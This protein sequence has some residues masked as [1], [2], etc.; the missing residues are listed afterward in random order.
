[1]TEICL[2]IAFVFCL[3]I[4][5]C[6]TGFQIQAYSSSK[7]R[8]SH[9]LD[10]ERRNLEPLIQT[11]HLKYQR[12]HND[13]T[14]F[15]PGDNA[16]PFQIKTLDGEFNYP[17]QKKSSV[18]IHAFTNKSAFLECL[19]SSNASL[20]DLVEYL[21]ENTHALFL[22]LDDSA[23]EDALWMREQVYHI[24]SASHR[25]KDVLSRLH[26]SPVPVFALGNWI[27]KVLYSWGCSGH[28]C[29]LAQA[30]FTS[31]A[32]NIPV[33]AK[34]LNARYD[35]LNGHWD[36]KP[37]RLRDGGDGCSPAS[38]VAGA[39]AW[40]TDS[41]CSFFTKVKNMAAS[42]AVGVLVYASTG[43][44]IKDMDCI[45]EECYT[46]LGIPAAMVHLEASV[47]NILRAGKEVNVS[48][49]T[50][51]SPNFFFGIDQQGVLCET[52]WLLYPTF[53]F[54]SWQ[55]QW[56]EYQEGLR[57]H[58]ERPATVVPVFDRVQMQGEHGAQ[59]TVDLPTGGLDYN[60]LEL[61]AS[62][63]CPGRRDETCAHWDHTVQLFVCCD[64][65]SPYCNM[66]LGRWIS[67]FRRGIGRWI[68]DVSPLMP[69]LNNGRCTFTM[70][71]VPWAMPW[72]VTLNLRFSQSNQSAILIKETGNVERLQPFKLTSLFD[73]GTFD[74]GYNKR[75]Q[76]LKFTIPTSTKKVELYAVITGHGSD[77]YGCGEF[78]VTSH[79][80]LV[81][82]IYNNTRI[83]DSA[84]SALGCALRVA[85]G[86]VPNEHGTWLYGRGG[87]CDGL[88]VNPWRV[89][90]TNQL[91]WS[92]ANSIHYFGL[93]EGMDPNPSSNPGYIV[94]CSYLVFYK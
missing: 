69:L 76:P 64:H 91:D 4:N 80:F 17:V 73:G 39:V 88:Q 1:M 47:D 3:F 37:Y 71:T 26:F 25:G 86:A 75:F 85:E 66:E 8:L 58:L 21:P 35:W 5:A 6:L 34:R 94:M 41:G 20:T 65:F 82:G 29:G 43:H 46:A 13:I 45:G 15:E 92:G 51:P 40:V 32:W 87:W 56:F 83:F 68:T 14:G 57:E 23:A 36:Q 38:S 24:A 30:V 78:C 7:L 49:Q 70:K 60:V 59:A 50:T 55:A 22:S 10:E 11:I 67:A 16:A 42:K 72:V 84:G 48:F 81:N 89:D 9:N 18:V 53:R 28:N 44:P 93:Y 77:E 79:H 2:I 52:G 33:I 27:P 12:K 74:K 19:W 54:L 62:L 31:I 61:D 63:S 90:L